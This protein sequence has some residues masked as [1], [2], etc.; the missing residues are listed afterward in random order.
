MQYTAPTP[1]GLGHNRP[2]P[3]ILADNHAELIQRAQDII[4]AADRLPDE[5][6]VDDGETLERLAA[7]VRQARAANATVDTAR[8]GEKKVFDDAGKAVQAFFAPV[9]DKLDR[10]KRKA[11]GVI[12]DRNRRAEDVRR[13]E[14][15]EAAERERQE[16][17]RRAE[18]ARSL[19]ADGKTAAS[20]PI[21]EHA[22]AGEQMAEALERKAVSSTADLVRT[23][24]GAGTVSSKGDWAFVIDDSAALRATLGKLADHFT[25]ADIEKAV[26]A[27]K[28]A[29]K[30][31]GRTP[32]LPGV[33]FSW[34]TSA[35]VR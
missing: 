27:F 26:R 32:A 5:C 11:E 35:V 14:A 7:Y 17:E 1:I 16:A 29:E 21:M 3:E 20:A 33:T 15:L 23:Q 30:K 18:V 22:V 13:R 2:I 24:T 25:Q 9:Q 6:D 34:T 10:A 4:D 31:A 8:S 19:E 12:N 28:T